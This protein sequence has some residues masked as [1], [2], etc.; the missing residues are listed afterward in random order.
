M[1]IA[2]AVAVPIR[3]RLA[4]DV[5][6]ARD[7]GT[8]SVAADCAPDGEPADRH[9]A[10]VDGHLERA[11]GRIAVQLPGRARD[12]QRESGGDRDLLK[13]I[14]AAQRAGDVVLDPRGAI[15]VRNEHAHFPAWRE[16]K[17]LDDL[18]HVA[19]RPAAR[20]ESERQA[21]VRTSRRAG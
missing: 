4:K 5:A 6:P 9:D 11:A 8:R 10:R 12:A 19:A 16:R 21:R 3:A 20:F 7:Y 17:A 2:H 18:Q 15:H 1:D 13:A 14:A